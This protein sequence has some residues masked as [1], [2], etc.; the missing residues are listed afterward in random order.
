MATLQA[1][2]P[3][4]AAQAIA[5][6]RAWLEHAVIGLNLCPFAKAV[7]VRGQVRYAVCESAD[8]EVLLQQLAD[9]LQ[10]LAATDAAEVDTC[11][12]IHPAA[13]TDFDDYNQFLD[14]AEALVEELGLD[15]VLQV[16]SFH[17]QYR[18]EGTEPGEIENATNQSPY[19]MLHL[20]REESIDRAVEA[21]PEPEAI[22]EANQRTL[23]ALGHEGWEALRERWLAD[24]RTSIAAAPPGRD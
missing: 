3:V 10:Q 18:F 12:L 13:L 6:T 20:L 7:H 23:A 21:F 17:P 2:G 15:G 11:L 1:G 16:A 8:P 22:Y 19:P 14:A 5:E 9:E 4:T 24:A